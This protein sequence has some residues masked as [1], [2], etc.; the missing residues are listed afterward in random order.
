[1]DYFYAVLVIY[2]TNT[3]NICL[4]LINTSLNFIDIN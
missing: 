4:V 3:L 2:S 1:M